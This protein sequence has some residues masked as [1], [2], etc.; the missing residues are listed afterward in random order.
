[1]GFEPVIDQDLPTLH[2]APYSPLTVES[3]FQVVA[4]ERERLASGSLT[5][6]RGAVDYRITSTEAEYQAPPLIVTDSAMSSRMAN[7]ATAGAVIA[8]LLRLKKGKADDACNASR[9]GENE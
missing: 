1:M 6:A 8:L 7:P 3:V 4:A 9:G 5:E 2:N